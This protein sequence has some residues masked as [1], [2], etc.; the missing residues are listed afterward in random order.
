M[1]RVNSAKGVS[2]SRVLRSGSFVL[3]GCRLLLVDELGVELFPFFCA[4][5]EEFPPDAARLGGIT[6]RL[7][8]V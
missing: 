3:T 5:L 8:I 2:G 4:L 7:K 6:G 1:K